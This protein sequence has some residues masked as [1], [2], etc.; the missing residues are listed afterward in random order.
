[1]GPSSSSD[2]NEPLLDLHV[3]LFGDNDIDS[4][5]NVHQDEFQDAILSIEKSLEKFTEFQ[6]QS[7]VR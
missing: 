3:S 5:T 6:Q 4:D 2:N 1:M 7:A